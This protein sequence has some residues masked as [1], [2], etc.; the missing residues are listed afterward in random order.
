[1]CKYKVGQQ[2][3]IKNKTFNDDAIIKEIN[4]GCIYSVNYYNF[5]GKKTEE[6]S[7]YEIRTTN[8]FGF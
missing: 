7:E 3:K 6:L 2:I 8:M 5:L 4:C 1:M